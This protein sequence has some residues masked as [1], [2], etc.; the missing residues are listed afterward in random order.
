M[1]LRL[2]QQDVD[3]WSTS[4]LLPL[5]Y[6]VGGREGGGVL[7]PE[8]EQLDPD[9]IWQRRTVCKVH[10]SRLC[11]LLRRARSILGCYIFSDVKF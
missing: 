2:I 7:S 10:M 4:V 11:S 6:G 8:S 9:M 3:S 5:S 1:T